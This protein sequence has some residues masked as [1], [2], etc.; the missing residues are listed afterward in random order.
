VIKKN[1]V[2]VSKLYK[3]RRAEHLIKQK[4]TQ[5]IKKLTVRYLKEYPT[6]KSSNFMLRF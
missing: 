5:H 3:I 4:Q 6:K 1:N 2:N